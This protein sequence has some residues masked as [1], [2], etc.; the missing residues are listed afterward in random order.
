MMEERLKQTSVSLVRCLSYAQAEVEAAVK[1]SIDLLGGIGRF[2][3]PDEKVLIKPNLMTISTPQEGIDTHPEVVRAVIRLVK[4]VTKNIYCG[5]SPSVWGER[6]DVSRVY[7]VSGIKDVCA[8]EGVELVYFTTAKMFG[9]YPLT[10]WLTRCERLISVPKFK[11]HGFAVLTAGIKNLFG[12][13]V[14][15]HKVKIH[16]DRLLPEDLSKAL[17]DIYELRR[18]DL[19]I[20]DGIVAMQGDG[21][22][23]GGSLRPMDLIAASVDALSID[24]VLSSVMGVAPSDIPTNREARHRGLAL[25]DLASIEIL[26]EDLKDFLT[27][28]FQL[29]KTT[30]LKKM[31]KGLLGIP[32]RILAMKPC[33]RHKRC[34]A[35]GLC[36]KI[37]PVGAIRLDDERVHMDHK[38]CVMCLCCQEICPHNAIDVKKSLLLRLLTMRK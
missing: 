5:D 26:G 21:P 16:R 10:D 3:K 22:G 9:A 1:R 29:P 37:C 23:S 7:E 33:V 8:Q 35:C 34:T 19:T 24:V 6:Q 2:V 31:P 38:K 25:A 32:K 28:D 15:M 30:Y 18:P 11:T 27:K 36:Q 12:L 20:L 13:V 17:V 4:S 14:G